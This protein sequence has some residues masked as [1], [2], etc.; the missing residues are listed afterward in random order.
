MILAPFYQRR[1][2]CD[3]DCCDSICNQDG[4]AVFFCCMSAKVNIGR[5]VMAVVAVQSTII[6]MGGFFVYSIYIVCLTVSAWPELAVR[7]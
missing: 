3:L 1:V 7:V 4:C 2:S 6:Y 5:E